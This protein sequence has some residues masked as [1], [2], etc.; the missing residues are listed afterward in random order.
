M[1]ALLFHFAPEP[2]T[3][4][5]E[6]PLGRFKSLAKRGRRKHRKKP[7]HHVRETS[8]EA[9]SVSVNWP[10]PGAEQGADFR[11][12]HPILAKIHS[13]S[14]VTVVDYSAENVQIHDM[15]NNDVEDFITAIPRPSWTKVRWINV[16]GLSWDV[17]R[18][19]ASHYGIHPLA[20][21]DIFNNHRIK[22]DSYENHMYLS[23]VLIAICERDAASVDAVR[24]QGSNSSTGSASQGI[25]QRYP[26]KSDNLDSTMS[27]AYAYHFNASPVAEPAFPSPWGKE[28]ARG[29]PGSFVNH[30]RTS[31]G[32]L[33][34]GHKHVRRK[35]KFRYH[36]VSRTSILNRDTDTAFLDARAL[37]RNYEITIEQMSFVLMKNGTLITFFNRASDLVTPPIYARLRQPQT[38]LRSSQDASFLVNS[39]IDDLVDHSLHVIDFYGSEVARMEIKVLDEPK[40]R[41]TSGQAELNLLKRTLS[42]TQ[43]V[44]SSLSTRAAVPG[45]DQPAG[46]DLVTKLTRTYLS[47][48]LD[49][50]ATCVENIDS[51][52][53]VA[54]DL[55]N[56][57]FNS[58][59]FYQNQTMQTL[60]V[61]NIIFLPLTFLAGVYG[62]NFDNIPELSWKFGYAYFWGLCLFVAG[63]LI[64]FFRTRRWFVS[65]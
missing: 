5:S 39:L 13:A 44:V 23:M 34:A 36:T 65:I 57:I 33:S 12:D 45:G 35:P 24:K 22:C 2:V 53:R 6:S 51:L 50:C 25:T 26:F 7:S 14:H 42:A 61:A 10:R 27:P 49:N 55:I 38:L 62:T 32:L 54:E 59:A 64:L 52:D 56:L 31:S 48:V 8:S 46:F 21:E 17:V 43:T 29:V 40:M 58:L 11:V 20:T 47:D 16:D 18:P 9:G 1:S 63:G 37:A 30:R 4:V 28:E 3:S 19:M 60:T 41:Y 15:G